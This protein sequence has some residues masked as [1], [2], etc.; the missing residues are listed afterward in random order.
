VGPTP[1][2]PGPSGCPAEGHCLG[3]G[4]EEPVAHLVVKRLRLTGLGD[5]G[6]VPQTVE[7]LGAVRLAVDRVQFAVLNEGVHLNTLDDRVLL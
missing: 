5:V 3:G 6:V 4:L 2:A 7:E 1:A